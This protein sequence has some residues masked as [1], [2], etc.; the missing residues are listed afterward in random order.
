MRRAKAQAFSAA[1]CLAR[2]RI[3]LFMEAVT[4]PH[5]Q[6]T[7]IYFEQVIGG[8]HTTRS[9]LAGRSPSCAGSRN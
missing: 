3:G 4:K 6:S 7:R 8:R 9:L 1:V 2:A 5:L